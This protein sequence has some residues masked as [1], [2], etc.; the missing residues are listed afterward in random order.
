MGV[1]SVGK[2]GVFGGAGKQPIV[3]AREELGRGLWEL[4]GLGELL[5]D[6]PNR[7]GPAL[8]PPESIS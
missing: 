6:E 3:W 4:S 8:S 2:V 1:E 5:G 7:L